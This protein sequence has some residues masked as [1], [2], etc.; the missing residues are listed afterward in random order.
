MGSQKERVLKMSMYIA[1]FRIFL[2]HINN[3]GGIKNCGINI[4]KLGVGIERDG[5][6]ILEV[7]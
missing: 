7:E 2:E 4:S 5:I 6:K 1:E 3:Q